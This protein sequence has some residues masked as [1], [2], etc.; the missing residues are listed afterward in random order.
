MFYRK[1]IAAGAFLISISHKNSFNYFNTSV[2]AEGLSTKNNSQAGVFDFSNCFINPQAE[3]ARRCE[4]YRDWD[5]EWNGEFMQDADTKN[6]DLSKYSKLIIF[7]SKADSKLK[8]EEQKSEVGQLCERLSS[9]LRTTS[10]LDPTAFTKLVYANDDLSKDTANIMYQNLKVKTNPKESFWL[11]CSAPYPLLCEPYDFASAQQ[12]K[13]KPI[14]FGRL[15]MEEARGKAAFKDVFKKADMSSNGSMELYVC[16]K[17]VVSMMLCYSLQ[18]PVERYNL[19]QL[20]QGLSYTVFKINGKGHTS[21]Q[22]FGDLA[23]NRS[24]EAKPSQS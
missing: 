7:V 8:T 22:T 16:D 2:N 12:L 6:S 1:S 4:L 20:D 10:L 11:G 5:P 21:C 18:L 19:F 23:F 17:E 13:Q 14:N 3:V 15:E 9:V 24:E